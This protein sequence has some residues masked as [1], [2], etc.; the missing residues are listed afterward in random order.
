MTSLVP[1]VSR[2]T[3]LTK[4]RK[5][6]SANL[7]VQSTSF[8]LPRAFRFA[9]K[10]AE[11]WTLNSRRCR[12]ARVMGNFTPPSNENSMPR[13]SELAKLINAELIGDPDA[14][15]TRARPFDLAEAGDVTLA[16][17]SRY[18]S[19]IDDSPATAFIVSAAIPGSTRNFIVAPSPKL[20]YARAIEALY[21]ISYKAIGVSGDL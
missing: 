6:T 14:Q 1:A 20:A 17:D 11:A 9:T 4:T 2:L 15:V 18:L 12:E 5:R 19:R 21:G 8:S 10:Q 3:R 7:G 13:L 16:M